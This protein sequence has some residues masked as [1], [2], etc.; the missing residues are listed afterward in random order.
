MAL[1]LVSALWVAGVSAGSLLLGL[2]I[3]LGFI[4]HEAAL[5]LVGGRGAR[6][7]EEQG[8]RAWRWL[9]GLLGV[10]VPGGVL[11]LV[12]A[13]WPA[14]VALLVA[15]A[16]G[17]VLLG[18]ATRRRERSMPGEFAAVTA[19]VSAAAAV[20]LAAGSPLDVALTMTL[21][22]WLAFGTSIFAV[23]AVLSRASSKGAHDDGLRNAVLVVALSGAG[24]V[25]AMW[26]GFGWAV[27]AALA[28]MALLS[29]VVCL[30]RRFSAKDL[31]RLGWG[32]A[33]ASTTTLGVLVA[34]L[35][36]AS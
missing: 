5:I 32:L 27:P 29:L 28:P 24:S 9:V 1:P 22:W 15:G 3:V 23:H 34:V 33:A 8:A 2:A 4:A 11:G 25:L 21:T 20:A 13:P 17:A 19:F 12:L 35:R 18:L 10:A 7:R 14:R 31:H 26:V 36:S 16:A 30:A 6:V